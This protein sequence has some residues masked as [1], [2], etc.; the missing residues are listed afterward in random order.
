ME[1]INSQN[2]ILSLALNRTWTDNLSSGL[3]FQGFTVTEVF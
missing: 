2:L 1:F 3:V